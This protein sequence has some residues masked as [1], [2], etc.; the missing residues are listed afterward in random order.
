MEHL[1]LTSF[2]H[3]PFLFLAFALFV[4]LMQNR[5]IEL[6]VCGLTLKIGCPPDPPSLPPSDGTSASDI[7]S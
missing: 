7:G 2:L 4:A 5:P 3:N 1:L 6:S